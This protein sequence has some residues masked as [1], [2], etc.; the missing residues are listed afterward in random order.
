[1]SRL[2]NA[3]YDR[4]ILIWLGDGSLFFDN[5]S[6]ATDQFYLNSTLFGLGEAIT[7]IFQK[8]DST[9]SNTAA[10]QTAVASTYA[11]CKLSIIEFFDTLALTAMMNR[12]G[13]CCAC[14]VLSI[15]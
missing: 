12:S 14:D 15:T 8:N 9:L 3:V 7:V 13:T 4:I 6:T 10:F 11:H 1:M 2:S 5:A